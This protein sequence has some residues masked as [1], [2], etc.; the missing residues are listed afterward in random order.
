MIATTLVLVAVFVPISFMPGNIGR[1]FGE[2]GITLAAA[3]LFS[4]LV[5]LTLTPMMRSQMCALGTCS[6]AASARAVDRLLPSLVA[7][8][9]APA[10]QSLIAAPG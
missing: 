2:F 7:R 10:A 9:P 8:L 4:A 5:A 3:V 6:A 1:L